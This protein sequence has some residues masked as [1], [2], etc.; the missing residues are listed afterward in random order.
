MNVIIKIVILFHTFCPY[1]CSNSF[2]S[3]FRD[4]F[5]FVGIDTECVT[6]GGQAASIKSFERALILLKYMYGITNS[7]NLFAYELTYF[8]LE[9]GSIQTQWH[10]SIQY[11]YVPDGT[12]LF[13]SYVNNFV[14]WYT[15]EALG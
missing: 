9:S 6:L 11:K 5:T 13:L 2:H 4:S 12:N 8:L 3:I 10:V 14:Y 7:G 15:Y 1:S